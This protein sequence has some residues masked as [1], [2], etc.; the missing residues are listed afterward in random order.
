MNKDGEVI[1]VASKEELQELRSE[2]PR[3]G[4]CKGRKGRGFKCF[5]L[6][7]PLT[8]NIG[9]E[10]VTFDS[11]V[12]LKAAVR[13]YKAETGENAERPTLVYPITV[14][15]DDE[16]QVVVNSKEELQAL[17]EACQEEEG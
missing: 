14:E 9:E 12:E 3:I 4:K 17:K 1:D 5:S 6:V 10:V 11:R 8:I 16:T 13:A 15:Y 2:C 7:F